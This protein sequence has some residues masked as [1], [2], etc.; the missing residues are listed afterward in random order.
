MLTEAQVEKSFRSLISKQS[1]S[2]EDI[3]KAEALFDN[4]RAESPLLHRLSRELDEIR[5]SQEVGTGDKS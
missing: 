3:E 1:L 4:L 5:N 2:E